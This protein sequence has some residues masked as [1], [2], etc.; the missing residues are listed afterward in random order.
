VRALGT[1][2]EDA[3]RAARI[4]SVDA[5]KTVAFLLVALCHFGGMIGPGF[6]AGSSGRAAC[7]ALLQYGSVGTDAFFVLSAF[8]FCRSLGRGFAWTE[9]AGRRLARIYPGFLAILAVYLFLAPLMPQV[10]KIPQDPFVAF[11]YVI[12]NLL[13]LP[14]LLPIAPIVTIAWSLSYVVFGYVFIGALYYWAQAWKGSREVRCLLWLGTTSLIWSAAQFAGFEHG[15]L[16]FFP[17]GALLAELFPVLIRFGRWHWLGAAAGASTIL[18]IPGLGA[19]AVG[20]ILF[21]GACL[22]SQ[23]LNSIPVFRLF[24]EFGRLSYAVFLSH[25]LVLRLIRLAHPATDTLGDFGALILATTSMVVLVALVF[26]TTVLEPLQ[27]LVARR[28]RQTTQSV[29]EP[30]A[31]VTRKFLA[32]P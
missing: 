32:M 10:T 23:H 28:T 14:G 9:A 17:A 2:S 16:L 6:P 4:A 19:R 30:Q 20:L 1:I 15:R 21:C 24:G 8:L 25:G 7:E 5:L 13:L 27:G 11:F 12:A 22:T 3:P 26:N 18:A 29:S 31:L